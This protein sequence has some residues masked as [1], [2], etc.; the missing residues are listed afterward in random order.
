MTEYTAKQY[1]EKVDEDL[2]NKAREAG[3]KPEQI[4]ENRCQEW[5]SFS[6]RTGVAKA[7]AVIRESLREIEEKKDAFEVKGI[8]A[9]ARDS[10]ER[11]VPIH[12]AILRSQKDGGHI[13]VSTYDSK[14]KVEGTN[15]KI[16]LPV[17]SLV[18]LNVK[19]N[20]Q[21]NSVDVVSIKE[22]VQLTQSQLTDILAKIVTPVEELSES[23]ER[24]LVI[25]S[26]KIRYIQAAAIFGKNYSEEGSK[27]R[28]S[29]YY[30]VLEKNARSP[31]VLHPVMQINFEKKDDKYARL[32]LG[33]M[34][35]A[36][37]T[38][39]VED[40]NALCEDA[41]GR[42]EDPFEQ[43]RMV[44]EG[45]SGREIYAIGYLVSYKRG[46]DYI[47]NIRIN[48]SCIVDIPSSLFL[49][50]PEPEQEPE[51]EPEPEKSDFD[52]VIDFIQTVLETTKMS[53]KDLN[54]ESIYETKF[55]GKVPKAVVE[56]AIEQI[57]NPPKGPKTA[58][59][60][61]EQFYS[62]TGDGNDST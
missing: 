1:L 5:E 22:Y 38:I 53:P 37:P 44:G 24:K 21:Y 57:R 47:D 26:G 36:L 6:F 25:V 43:S 28:P 8:Y 58:K 23:E 60:W 12:M 30:N 45:L 10:F 33:R 39:L 54:A 20:E 41:M 40:F 31:P 18:T 13:E 3:L 56:D 4:I 50:E 46:E 9:G 48:A 62:Q 34:R 32:A 2:L 7:K 27:N 52:K 17:P 11:K 49:A 42:S 55:K 61:R 16:E 35:V 51:Q 19:I 29:A 15:S 59:Q 14:L